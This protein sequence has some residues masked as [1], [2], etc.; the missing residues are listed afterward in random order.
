MRTTGG[1]DDRTAPGS[2]SNTF[3]TARR[4]ADAYAAPRNSAACR[5]SRRTATTTSRR[6]SYW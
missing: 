1:L 2:Y 6:W 5:S 3:S 4:V